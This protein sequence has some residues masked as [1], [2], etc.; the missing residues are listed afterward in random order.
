L[1]VSYGFRLKE[2]VN[3]YDGGGLGLGGGAKK[4]KLENR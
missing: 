3:T 4:K 2:N 1:G